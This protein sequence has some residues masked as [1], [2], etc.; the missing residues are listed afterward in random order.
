M[1]AVSRYAEQHC[2][3]MIKV[4]AQTGEGV[5]AMF[6]MMVDELQS[7]LK[8]D[9]GVASVATSQF[10]ENISKDDQTDRSTQLL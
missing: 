2:W 10:L 8:Y 6:D 1:G 7:L 9:R 3:P 4:S 5:Q